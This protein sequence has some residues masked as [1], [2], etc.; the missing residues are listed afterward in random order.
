M[1]TVDTVHS[2]YCKTVEEKDR[3]K[4]KFEIGIENY[5]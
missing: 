4:E 3:L 1:R 5:K 2:F